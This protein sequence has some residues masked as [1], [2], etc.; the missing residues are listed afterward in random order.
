MHRVLRPQLSR[1]MVGGN[2]TRPEARKTSPALNERSTG[3][4]VLPGCTLA[5]RTSLR[6]AAPYPEK[7]GGRPAPRAPSRCGTRQH[8]GNA[9]QHCLAKRGGASVGGQARLPPRAQRSA[10]LNAQQLASPT[11]T[12]GRRSRPNRRWPTDRR[13]ARQPSTAAASKNAATEFLELE[14]NGA[15]I[16]PPPLPGARRICQHLSAC[17]RHR[18]E[19]RNPPTGKPIGKARVAKLAY[20]PG[21]WRKR[22]TFLPGRKE[23]AGCPAAGSRKPLAARL[24]F[25]PWVTATRGAGDRMG[26]GK[27]SYCTVDWGCRHDGRAVVQCRRWVGGDGPPRNVGIVLRRS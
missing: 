11:D 5:S 1:A 7:F 20:H 10:E 18:P 23:P 4:R 13:N 3:G 12:A 16:A 26:E 14:V 8:G 15:T 2:S 17:D 19:P 25:Q 22:F 9:G 6:P 21:K 24:P 27:A